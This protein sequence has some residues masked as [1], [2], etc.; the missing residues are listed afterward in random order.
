MTV[1]AVVIVFG[2]A[3]VFVIEM[4]LGLLRIT[5]VANSSGGGARKMGEDG[6]LRGKREARN[7]DY[8]GA[9]ER[10]GWEP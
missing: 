6:R 10:R 4:L 5:T 2:V 7:G 3:F 1:I 8:D 9:K